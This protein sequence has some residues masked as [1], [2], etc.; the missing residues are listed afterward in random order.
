[1][2]KILFLAGTRPEIIK[3][4]PIF[5]LLKNNKRIKATFCTTGQH[6][7][8]VLLAASIFKIKFDY[9]LHVMKKNQDLF[10]L[11]ANILKKLRIFFKKNFFDIVIVQGDTTSAMI[12]AL[13]AFYSKTKIIHIEAGLRSNNKSN[14]FPEEINRVLISRIADIHCA[15]TNL[16]KNNLI[17]EGIDESKIFLTGNTVID[18]LSLIKDKFNLKNKNSKLILCTIHRKEN[19]GKNLKLFCKKLKVIAKSFKDW[20]FLFIFHPNPNIRVIVNNELKNTNNIEV[21]QSLNYLDFLRYLCKSSMVI[22]DSGG[23]QEECAFLGKFIVIIR[24]NTERP[25]II[26][27]RLGQLNPIKN[28][29][30]VNDIG[31]LIKNKVWTNC[32]SSFCFGRGESSKKIS[33]II[34]KII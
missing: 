22:S 24:D 30:F 12:G 11:S 20:K 3:L 7:E 2:K 33:K 21:Q 8:L 34:D 26:S 13:S 15:P 16:S 19:Q 4:A 18:S 32:S 10:L 29:Q 6:R 23:L 9:N 31:N 28:K 5:L 17:Q 1:M 25:E 14:P 27:A